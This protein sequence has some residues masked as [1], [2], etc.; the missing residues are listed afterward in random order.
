MDSIEFERFNL[1]NI[2][3]PKKFKSLFWKIKKVFYKNL[4]GAE[5]TEEISFEFQRLNKWN[6]HVTWV[7]QKS[8]SILLVN[9]R[10]RLTWLFTPSK[11]DYFLITFNWNREN[12]SDYMKQINF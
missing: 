3:K 4:K 6:V 8:V 11:L 7:I 2:F 10:L 1:I 5:I 9:L 12:T